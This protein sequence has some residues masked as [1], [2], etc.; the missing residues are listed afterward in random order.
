M[1]MDVSFLN[2]SLLTVEPTFDVSS[3]VNNRNFIIK[4][5][6]DAHVT[7]KLKEANL[8]ANVQCRVTHGEVTATSS[9]PLKRH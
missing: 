9:P 8:E 1:E 2:R 6:A 3:T 5:A 7:C 4:D